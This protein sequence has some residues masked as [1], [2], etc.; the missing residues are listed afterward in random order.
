MDTIQ[1][2]FNNREIAIGLWI[3]VAVIALLFT[4]TFREFLKTAISILFCKKFV[5]FYIVFISYLIMIVSGLKYIELWNFELLKDTIFWVL[6][7][8]LPL[9]TKTIEK[10]DGVHF[11]SKLIEENIAVAV[12]IQFFVGFWTFNLVIELVIVPITVLISAL[13]A[14]ASNDKKHSSVRRFF[15][16]M[17]A[18]WGIIILINAIYGLIDSPS[19]FFNGNT[20]KSFILPV[21]LLI[22]NLPVI[23]GLALYSMYENVFVR[24][25][26]TKNE[27]RKMKWQVFCFAGISL[28]KI[29]AIRK[30][31]PTTIAFCRNSGQ[32]KLNL[33]NLSRRLE[34]QI[35]DNYMKRSHFYIV[36]CVIGSL[37]SLMGLIVT[38]SDVSL[39][40]LVTLNFVLDIPR[41]KEILTYIFSTS[42]VLCIVLLFF[43]IG[44]NKKQREDITQIKKYALYELLSAVKRQRPELMEYPSLDSPEKLFDAYVLN[45]Y[46]IRVVCDKV[47]K[48]YENLL[49]T[50][51]REIVK[52]L[53]L[54]AM[55]VSD[56]FGIKIENA[57]KYTKALFCKFYNE[58]VQNS[59]QNEKINTYTYTVE[60][61]LKKYSARVNEFFEEFKYY[62]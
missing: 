29:S 31:L 41:I 35:G 50:W 30:N 19:S 58:K 37:I 14:V 17:F 33:T 21:I 47:L 56:N 7:V 61:D 11:F 62:Y 40:D 6:F 28:S 48:A 12:V 44:F 45:A 43:V 1:N 22:F 52:D 36:A 39:K 59:P 18:L 8:E 10:A 55:I 34:L 32:L 49:T 24:I 23:Y 38:N 60:T 53:Q 3:I 2:I 16:V 5:V 46:D 54:S 25:Q 15:E 4:R 9:F 26:G 27:Q 42:I 20:L 57:D 13:Y 51:E